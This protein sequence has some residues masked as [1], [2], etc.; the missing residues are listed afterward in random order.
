[1]VASTIINMT[2]RK[3]ATQVGPADIFPTLKDKETVED[4]LDAFFGVS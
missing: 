3:N 4:A 1:M 2:P